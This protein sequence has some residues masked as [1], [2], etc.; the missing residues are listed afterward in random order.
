MYKLVTNLSSTQS[1]FSQLT[2]CCY[3]PIKTS[4]NSPDSC[5][6]EQNIM[7]RQNAVEVL[8]SK[9]LNV[10]NVLNTINYLENVNF[11][12]LQLSSSVIAVA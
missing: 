11:N 9:K 2:E 12:E 4:L 5:K 10:G 6:C 3:A 1:H 8:Y 7:S